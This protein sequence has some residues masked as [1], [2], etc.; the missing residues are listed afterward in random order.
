[1]ISGR[2]KEAFVDWLRSR[3]QRVTRE[4]LALLDEIFACHEHLDADSLL[5][6]MQ[7]RGVKISRATVYR[8][9]QLLVDA[10]AVRKTRLAGDRFVFEHVHRGQSHDHLVCEECGRI[11]EFVSPAVRAM[12]GEVAR[13]HGFAA[14][15]HALQLFGRCLDRACTSRPGV[16]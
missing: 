14:S 1:M 10:G 13:A 12:L 16:S 2:E 4:R 9:L 8:N 11:V 15:R 7:R 3:G 5:A 6:A